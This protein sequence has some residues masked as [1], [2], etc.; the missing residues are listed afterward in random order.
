MLLSLFYPVWKRH[1]EQASSSYDTG[2]HWNDLTTLCLSE[3]L[4]VLTP[5]HRRICLPLS[6]KHT[7]LD[8]QI[9]NDIV[10]LDIRLVPP[11]R[12][13]EMSSY[14]INTLKAEDNLVQL[15]CFLC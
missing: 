7:D 11:E 15:A 4:L 2:L 6:Q 13:L 14:C 3:A 5:K 9:L 12:I 1:F 8:L 10:H